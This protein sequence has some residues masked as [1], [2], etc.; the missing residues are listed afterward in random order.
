MP[1]GCDSQATTKIYLHV[2]RPCCIP[3][4]VT[5]Q[6]KSGYLGLS[7]R[8][9]I[10][11]PELPNFFEFVLLLAQADRKAKRILEQNTFTSTQTFVTRS[12]FLKNSP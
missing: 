12:P 8:H 7:M 10:P 9:K 5:H 11:I 2:S 3:L 6:V 1:A 4:T